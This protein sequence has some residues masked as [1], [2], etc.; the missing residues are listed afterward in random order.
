MSCVRW[1]N[2]IWVSQMRAPLEACRETAGSYN[3]LLDVLYVFEHKT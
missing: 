1:E 3:R 2:I